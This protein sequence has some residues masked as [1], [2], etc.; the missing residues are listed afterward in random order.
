[1][2]ARTPPVPWQQAQGA[3]AE[4]AAG[5]AE[6]EAGPTP[7]EIPTGEVQVRVGEL[8]G[9]IRRR[10]GGIAVCQLL[11]RLKVQAANCRFADAGVNA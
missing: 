5:A 3:A 10:M 6:R 2:Y 8:V 4:G 9:R 1:M 7:L 11:G